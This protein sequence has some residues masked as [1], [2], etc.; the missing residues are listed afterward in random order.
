MKW[1]PRLSI[2]RPIST[3]MLFVAVM[4]LGLISWTRIPLEL[5]PNS[6]SGGNLW[7]NIPYSDA[8][9][10]ETEEKITLPVED[11]LSDLAGLKMV[12]SS[13]SSGRASFS[14]SFHRSVDMSSAYNGVVDRMER[15]LPDLPEDSQEYFIYKWNMGDAPILWAGIGMEGTPEEKYNLLFKVINKKLERVPGVGGVNSWGADPKSIFIDFQRDALM[16][17]RISQWDLLQR[18]RSDFPFL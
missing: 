15:L 4:V 18:I 16:E 5:L 6:F 10:R 1:L 8:Q 7:M 12:R 11:A 9:P 3:I 2:Y 17:Q 13:S 14:L